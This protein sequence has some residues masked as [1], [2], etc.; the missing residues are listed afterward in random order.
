MGEID[1]RFEKLGVSSRVELVLYAVSNAKS[2]RPSVTP[3]EKREQKP[4]GKPRSSG[5]SPKAADQVPEP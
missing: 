4:G 1:P 3:S 5:K 2:V